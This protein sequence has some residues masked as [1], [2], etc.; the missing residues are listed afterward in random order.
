MPQLSECSYTKHPQD[1]T[2]LW[3]DF[4]IT[5]SHF[6]QFLA[7][8]SDSS[9]APAAS[10]KLL[11]NTITGWMIVNVGSEGI[12]ISHDFSDW[13]GIT[14]SSLL[15]RTH[16]WDCPPI[17]TVLEGS[18]SQMTPQIQSPFNIKKVKICDFTP[19]QNAGQDC[20]QT[21]FLSYVKTE[22]NPKKIISLWL[23][24]QGSLYTWEESLA[25]LVSHQ[26]SRWNLT[27]I[28]LECCVIWCDHSS[29]QIQFVS[30]WWPECGL[31]TCHSNANG[32]GFVLLSR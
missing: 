10:S 4:I 8:G 27:R 7:L 18:L 19:F 28:I 26:A 31:H 12:P 21:W 5:Q 30:L 16:S 15:H 6:L 24:T 25:F 9:T 14:Y 3:L 11:K 29:F 1:Q 2:G 32:N 17:L 13:G 20:Y 22:N 23:R